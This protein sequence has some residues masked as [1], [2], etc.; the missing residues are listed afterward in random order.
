MSRALA[1]S[2]PLL[3][4]LVALSGCERWAERRL[5]QKCA[6]KLQFSNQ[7]RL[8]LAPGAAIPDFIPNYPGATQEPRNAGTRGDYRLVVQPFRTPDRTID[9]IRFYSD[10]IEKAGETVCP[11]VVY[12]SFGQVRVLRDDGAVI[13][14]AMRRGDVTFGTIEV[15]TQ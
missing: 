5:A 3:A 8:D 9:V 2:V 15:Y 4:T 13:V 10:R 6:V 11:Y 1:L 7:G 14:N 12:P